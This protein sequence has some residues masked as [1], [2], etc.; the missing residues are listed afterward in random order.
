MKIA[1][2]LMT[3]GLEYDDRIR[4]E[5]VT[6][7][8]IM[9][10]EFKVFA[11]HGDNHAEKGIL[12]YGVPYEVVSLKKRG[13]NKGLVSL[14]RKEY[15]FYSQI[16]KKV[17]GYDLLW[18]CD[19][20]PFFFPLFSKKPMIWDLHEIPASIIGTR[21]KNILFHRMEKR[22]KYLIH[23]NQERLD[24]LIS[25]GVVQMPDKNLII[26]NYPDKEWLSKADIEHEKF[27]KFKEWLG[28]DEYIYV[29]GLNGKGRF[30]VETLSAI[31]EVK[32]IK[33][34]VIGNVSND[35]KSIITSKYHDVD[36]HLYYTGQVVQSETSV[37]MAHCKF[38]LVFYNVITANNRYC[39]PNRMFQCMGMGRPV[40]VGNNEPMRNV[41]E[42]YGNGVVLRSDGSDVEETVRGI[43]QMLTNYDEFRRNAE[44]VKDHFSWEAQK[45]IFVN[46]FSKL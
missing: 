22:C 19:D 29:Q 3:N 7:S 45:Q 40:V 37:F 30:G 32:S 18:I 17:K 21:L 23:A 33:A 20:Q 36:Q 28:D 4:K 35:I 26:R 38:S 39:E 14:L 5:M 27:L 24:Y 31:M 6:I 42:K 44:E 15:D 11:F 2:I 16:K 8:H 43:N 25:K 9:D 10:V 41:V 13:G 1:Y 34:V 12:S 46:I